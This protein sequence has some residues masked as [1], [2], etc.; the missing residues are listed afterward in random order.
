[1]WQGHH[2]GTSAGP[3]W[4]SWASQAW[5]AA[6][7]RASSSRLLCAQQGLGGGSP[8]VGGGGSAR[9][10]QLGR[11]SA[12]PCAHPSQCCCHRPQEEPVR[13]AWDTGR[14]GP[15]GVSSFVARGALG[16]GVGPKRQ[17]QRES[18]GPSG[19]GTAGQSEGEKRQRKRKIRQTAA[20]AKG[21]EK[22]ERS[23]EETRP[24]AEQ[25]PSVDP[26]ATADD[27]ARLSLLGP[28]GEAPQPGRLRYS[29]ARSHLSAGRA[30][31]CPS[32]LPA[33]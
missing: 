24:K 21:K 19:R 18:A 16:D 26:A 12:G 11:L 10:L 5:Q 1:M 31:S 2:G 22:E 30:G 15:R 20:G 13:T 28:P 14:S 4:V 6:G 32:S 9:L 33:L 23:K 7:L 17:E 3:W 27:Q 8:Q 29:R 25:R